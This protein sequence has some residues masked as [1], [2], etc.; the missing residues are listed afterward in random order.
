MARLGRPRTRID[1]Q[2]FF[3]RFAAMTEGERE[4]AL[5]VMTAVHG[6]LAKPRPEE[7]TEEG[8]STEVTQK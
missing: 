1:N 4:I 5:Q 2:E 7:P 3:A 8:P 6:A